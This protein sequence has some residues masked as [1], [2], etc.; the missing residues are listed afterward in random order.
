MYKD[1][2]NIGEIIDYILRNRLSTPRR[3][4][5]ALDIYFKK[6][7]IRSF[8]DNDGIEGI[9]LGSSN[10]VHVVRISIEG[11]RCT[12][13]DS[14]TNHYL[15]KHALALLYHVLINKKMRNRAL[16]IITSM[17][18]GIENIGEIPMSI[19]IP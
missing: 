13:S 11:Y 10:G 5:E 12:C 19:P 18:N 14:F 17:L 3:I 16:T 7:I 2:N 9:V 8:I 6:G 1:L 15:C 4:Y